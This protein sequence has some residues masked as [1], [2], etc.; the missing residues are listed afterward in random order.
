MKQTN[1]LKSIVALTSLAL[2]PFLPSCV[3]VP[4]EVQNT[5]NARFEEIGNK[6]HANAEESIRKIKAQNEQTLQEISAETKTAVDAIVAEIRAKYDAELNR[7]VLEISEMSKNEIAG[8]ELAARDALRAADQALSEGKYPEAKIFCLNAINHSPNGLQYFQRLVEIQ[9]HI[10][11]TTLEDWE[12]IQGILDLGVY[13]VDGVQEIKAL[14]A[15]KTDVDRKIKAISDKAEKEQRDADYDG[16]KEMFTTVIGG[17]LSLNECG[18]DIALLNERLALLNTLSESPIPFQDKTQ[19]QEQIVGEI[20]KSAV[21]IEY[22]SSLKT[23]RNYRANAERLVDGSKNFENVIDVVAEM[24][25]ANKLLLTSLG[26]LDTDALPSTYETAVSEERNKLAALEARFNEKRSAP[27]LKEVETVKAQ[28][29]K[30]DADIAP[31]EFSPDIRKDGFYTKQIKE[32]QAT[33]E[34]MVD[35]YSRVYV[36]SAKEDFE[37]EM[38]SHKAKIEEWSKA[39]VKAYQLWACEKVLSAAKATPR[40][41]GG[42]KEARKIIEE[43]LLSI[44]VQLLEPNVLSLYQETLEKQIKELS[45]VTDSWN[46]A[47]EIREKLAKEPKISQENF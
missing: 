36:I 27:A 35:A 2:V 47:R 22:Y 18:D 26:A 33:F 32:R 38:K 5:M 43:Y 11:E 14:V 16:L 30:L 20:R 29:A 4:Q 10:P 23:S 8:N 45:G 13:Q 21:R 1:N 6:L 9:N 39:R 3:P 44:D 19:Y 7:V 17:R 28:I 25:A 31:A 12:Q 15:L 37:K 42:N 41:S 34:K 40:F 24:L 46:H